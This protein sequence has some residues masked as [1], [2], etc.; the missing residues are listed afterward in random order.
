MFSR[1]L[2]RAA[3]IRTPQFASYVSRAHPQKTPEFAVPQAF[4]SILQ[5][6]QDRIAFRQQKWE[7]NAQA[8]KEKRL[9]EGADAASAEDQGPYRN[10]DETVSMAINLNLDPRRPGQALRGTVALPHGTGK[11][12]SV[13]VFTENADLA[14]TAKESGG[15]LHA[16]GEELIDQIANGEVTVDNLDRSLATQEIMPKLSKALARVLGPRGLMPNPKVGT[17]FTD[18]DE[19][20]QSLQQQSQNVQ[21]RTE[22][23]GIVHVPIG[24]ASFGLDKLVDNARSV[25]KELQSVKPDKYGKGKSGK[26]MGKNVRYWLRASVSAT[27]GRGVRLD[28]RTV[29]PSSPYFMKDPDS[30]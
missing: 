18:A 21:Y 27:Q 2:H 23:S 10:Q 22:K 29:D 9:K 13:M 4:E 19:L 17:L 12:V 7:R 11:K 5:D 1:A 28:M 14:K 24:K 26:K 6:T 15:A 30:M 3:I 25:C 8:R 16:G 20:L